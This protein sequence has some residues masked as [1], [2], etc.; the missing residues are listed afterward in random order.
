MPTPIRK[1]MRRINHAGDVRFLTFSCFQRLQLLANPA[2]RS[3]VVDAMLLA[4][5]RHGFLLYAWVVMPEHIHLLIEPRDGDV[6]VPLRTLKQSVSKRCLDRW[7]RLR[8]GVLENIQ[9]DNGS[10]RFWQPGGGFD[11]NVRDG[12]AFMRHVQYI[13]RNPVERGLVPSPLEWEWSSA[14][15]WAGQHEGTPECDPPPGNPKIWEQWTGY[16]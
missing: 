1:R 6:D 4:R 16:L 8:A 5:R 10:Y 2:V 12:A 14:R 15:W 11:R 13:H 9:L 7:K 3:V